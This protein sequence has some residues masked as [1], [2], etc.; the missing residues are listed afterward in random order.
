MLREQRIEQLQ[1]ALGGVEVTRFAGD[2]P[3]PLQGQ[4]RRA[5]AGRRGTVVACFGLWSSFSWSW[6][7]KKNPPVAGS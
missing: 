3:Q 1:R 6:L 5:V 2:M 4:R 7:V